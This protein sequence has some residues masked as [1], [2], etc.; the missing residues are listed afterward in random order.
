[1]ELVA[2][3]TF[4]MVAKEGGIVAASRQMNT[5][6]SNITTRIQ[7]L[8]NE[9][10]TKL[11]HRQGR[12]LKLSR[13]GEVLLD[14]AAQ[15]LQLERQ[16]GVA[17][18]LAGKG[19]AELKI[20]GMETFAATQLPQFLGALREVC[21]SLQPRIKTATTGELLEA[22]LEHRLDCAFVGGPID[23]PDLLTTD[24][25]MQELVLVKPR[26]L[27]PAD[28]LILFREGCV[29][30]AKAMQWRRES[31]QVA[32]QVSELGTL[33]GLLGCVAQGLGVTLM[34]RSVVERSSYSDSLVM[35]TLPEHIARVP[36]QFIQHRSTPRLKVME[37]LFESMLW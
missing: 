21:P 12:G 4:E 8:E 7:R 13:S 33:E 10:G 18:R 19:A 1:M 32:L 36:T 20:G 2:L 30:R 25:L 28:N 9:L 23:H 29:Y 35:E 31:G 5:V 15:I 24:V 27:E 26:D 37:R 16:A 17:V 6:Q 34:P 14:Y 11:F 3:K 22:V